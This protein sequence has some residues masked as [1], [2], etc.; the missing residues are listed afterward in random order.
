MQLKCSYSMLILCWT[1]VLWSFMYL[2][3]IHI[4]AGRLHV[5]TLLELW[6]EPNPVFQTILSCALLLHFSPLWNEQRAIVWWFPENI[7]FFNSKN[8]FRL[9]CHSC[10][11]LPIFR[12]WPNESC[13]IWLYCLRIDIIKY[14]N[15]ISQKYTFWK[16]FSF[17]G[18]YCPMPILHIEGCHWYL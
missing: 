14:I 10:K 16:W 18:M 3:P 9:F 7:P 4:S 17:A 6:S 2:C 1:P 12:H 15:V 13:L 8:L 11:L 5:F